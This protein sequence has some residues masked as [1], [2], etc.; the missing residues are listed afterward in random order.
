MTSTLYETTD[1]PSWVGPRAAAW[2]LMTAGGIAQPNSAEASMGRGK[3]YNYPVKDGA[4]AARKYAQ[5]QNVNA[6]LTN[7]PGTPLK[8]APIGDPI[9]TT[10]PKPAPQT[11]GPVPPTVSAAPGT[12]PAPPPA[13]PQDRES[14]AEQKKLDPPQP[15][16]NVPETQPPNGQ[17]QQQPPVGNPLYAPPIPIPGVKP[18]PESDTKPT[19]LLDMPNLTGHGVGDSW[20]GVML[21]LRPVKYTIPKGNGTNSVDLEITNPDGTIDHWRIARDETGG[22]QHWHDDANGQSSYATWLTAESRWAV[23]S[24]APGV[25]TSGAPS[26]ALEADPDFKKVYT[27]S[28][29]DGVRVGTDIGKLNAFG[30]YDNYHV[31]NY[32]NLTITHTRSDGKGGVDSRLYQQ[33]D[34]NS[35]RLGEDGEVWEVGPD[36]QGRITKGRSVE[37]PAGTHLYFIDQNN[38]LFDSFRGIKT[39]LGLLPS[40]T[41]RYADNK[42]S[43]KY[44]DGS[45]IVY[46]NDFKVL[47]PL[48]GPPDRRGAVQKTMEAIRAAPGDMAHSIGNWF[49][50]TS[51]IDVLADSIANAG[52]PYYTPP[53]TLERVATFSEGIATP[54]KFAGEMIL[55]PYL[56]VAEWTGRRIVAGGY[57][58]SSFFG[59]EDGRRNRTRTASEIL[60]ES[61]STGEAALMAGLL[62]LP[63]VGSIARGAKV[64]ISSV[65]RIIKNSGP[66]IKLDNYLYR[67]LSFRFQS[68][69]RYL[70]LGNVSRAL[71]NTTKTAEVDGRKL[72]VGDAVRL[73]LPQNEKMLRILQRHEFLEKSLLSNPV[74]LL[75]LLQH[76][77]AIDIIDD[78]L[79]GVKSKTQV[80]VR[81]GVDIARE[82]KLTNS[83]RA[84]SER[85]SQLYRKKPVQPGFDLERKMEDEYRLGFIRNLIRNWPNDQ[86]EVTRMAKMIEDE[87]RGKAH[88]RKEAK[89]LT[90]ADAKVR[91]PKDYNFDASELVDVVAAKVIFDTVEDIYRAVAWLERDSPFEILRFKDRFLPPMKSGYRDILM[92]VRAPSGQVAELRLHLAGI[93][94]RSETFEH[95]IFEVTRDMKTFA[96]DAG[97]EMN[98]RELRFKRSVSDETNMIFWDALHEG[99][100]KGLE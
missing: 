3:V 51:G 31:D 60:E 48:A 4:A 53:T 13:P 47:V 82:S 5:I 66:V 45:S 97:R 21:D 6:M 57:Y 68:A 70:Q 25:S 27:P 19:S 20:D 87:F 49:T 61:P 83:Q 37:T 40:Y 35:W 54:V 17:Q 84:L 7:D 69:E 98:A 77:K 50:R 93:E 72:L 62:L 14:A 56:T 96:D 9:T 42:I 39:P 59:S 85:M 71:G 1:P 8:A 99:L 67:N 90:R 11:Q 63:M 24:F 2:N 34:S 38:V 46:D 64:G 78:V 91:D 12:V 65:A 33:L 58:A 76:P 43:R 30:Y 23:Q 52:N 10:P 94:N 89:S 75:N 81:G 16:V 15:I 55:D 26:H 41:D 29:V 44:G 92:N 95:T 32:G 28:F 73:L 18:S 86:A 79:K 88:G 22:L 100:P 80:P 36:L 74:T